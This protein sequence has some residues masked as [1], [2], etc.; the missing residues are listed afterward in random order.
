VSAEAAELQFMQ[1]LPNAAA[2]A[3][4]AEDRALKVLLYR[5]PA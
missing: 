4:V 2:F 3:D 5:A 1:R